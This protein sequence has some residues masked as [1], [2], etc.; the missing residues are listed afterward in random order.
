M[1]E[2]RPQEV[3]VLRFD[4]LLEE[5][6]R[7]ASTDLPGAASTLREALLLWRGPALDDLSD[8]G[9]LRSDIARLEERRMVATED[10]IA[11]DLALGAHRELIPELEALVGRHTLR[12]RLWGQLM[13]ALVSIRPAG[14]R[15]GRLP[16][17]PGD[18]RRPSSASIPRP[19]SA[20][21]RTRSFRQ[22]SA[23]GGDRGAVARLSAAE[24]DRPG[25][26][27]VVW[28]AHSPIWPARSR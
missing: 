15:P 10:R 2:V 27:R 5:A 4:A 3:D 1:L 23:L 19:S 17:G 25:R 12:E 9:S 11:A 24:A 16:P 22:D 6:K 28:L 8:Q 20:S 14:G 26:P 21:S 18:P 7:L 13:V